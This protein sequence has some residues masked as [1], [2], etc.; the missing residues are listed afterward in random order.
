M[1]DLKHPRRKLGAALAAAT[2][3]VLLRS[4]TTEAGHAG[5]DDTFHLRTGI[6]TPNL[7]AITALVDQSAPVLNSQADTTDAISAWAG[8]WISKTSGCRKIETS[9][10]PGK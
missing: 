3:L 8:R 2:G 10:A 1:L 9:A 7:D 5:P 6:A 4:G